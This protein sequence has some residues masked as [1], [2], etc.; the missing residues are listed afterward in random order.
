[1][2]HQP[3]SVS[4]AHERRAEIV[5]LVGLVLQA[6]IAAFLLLV[7]MWNH[8][9]ATQAEWRHALG[10]VGI[11]LVL[12][13]VWH[14][15]KLVAEES[16]ELEQLRREREAQGTSAIFE[17]ADEEVLYLAR[18]RLQWIYRWV[19][20]IATVLLAGYHITVG[21]LW[22][23][24]SLAGAGEAMPSLERASP[25]V[26]FLGG[27]GFVAFLLSRYAAGMAREPQW[28]MLRAGASYL[29]GNALVCAAVAIS[30][31]MA[32]F[33]QAGPER[34]L[35][36]LI[37]V[38]LLVLGAE[39]LLNLLLDFYRPRTPGEEPRPAFDSRFL[40]LFSEPGGLAHSIAEAINYQFGFEVSKTWFY[41]LM[42]RAILPLIAFGI[43]SLIGLSAIVVVDVSEQAYVERFG[44]LVSQEP[45]T[46][47]FHW[48]WPWPIERVYRRPVD[49]IARVIVGKESPI[50]QPK[51][52][53][54]NLVLWTEA[55][56]FVPEVELLVAAPQQVSGPQPG[57]A[58]VAT[59]EQDKP[60]AGAP[61]YLLRASVPV[62]YRVRDLKR[63]MY[64]HADPAKLLEDIAFRE[65][66]RY[67]AGSD[68]EKIMAGDRTKMA[69][70][71]KR[72]IQHEADKLKL[73]VEIVLVGLQNIHPPP[74][75]Q[76]AASFEKVIT[77]R[78]EQIASEREAEVEK[79]RILTEVAGDRA[80][81]EA[82]YAAIREAADP[83][84]PP[85]RRAEALERQRVLIFGDPDRG[86]APIGGEAAEIIAKA[87]ARSTELATAARGDA[88]A[89]KS[90]LAA[91]RA[92]P[93][94]YRMRR[95]LEVLA[96]GLTEDIRKYVIAANTAGRKLVIEVDERETTTLEFPSE[97]TSSQ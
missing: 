78:Q 35:A 92:A 81:A 62:Q 77:A 87:R 69:A 32:R 66:V 22:L 29:F 71:L 56:P 18:R 9:L 48:K 17:E 43:L 94:L 4:T 7:G 80:R 68:L 85:E 67:A 58:P 38:L 70:E 15:R 44:R 57:T 42:Q 41:K 97:E 11:W 83:A 28:R 10:G 14:Q 3:M 13:L 50:P 40:A 52:Q 5:S 19:L 79:T 26:A 49:R 6:T 34:A 75:E 36:Y 55:H 27:T 33:G 2:S 61:V 76:V 93:R 25:S 91:Y 30:L 12:L 72:R 23:Y 16:L 96:E 63:Y 54:K 24:R 60:E 90:E 1:M 45:L 51:E 89:F 39:F 20:P 88:V 47:G 74:D 21:L 46:P 53:K 82:L 59:P 8:S 84:I 37:G 95:Y 31:A 65:V 64:E 73:G 86:I